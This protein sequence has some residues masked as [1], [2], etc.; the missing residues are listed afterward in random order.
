M[1]TCARPS[2]TESSTSPASPFRTKPKVSAMTEPSSF[3]I[4]N[5]TLV[6]PDRVVE[7]GWLA[8]EDGRIAELGEGAPPEKGFD[9]QGDLLLP[10]LVELHTDHLEAHYAPR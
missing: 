2:P 8:V 7:G 1:T 3:L 9:I 10:G 6:L 4:A 5:A